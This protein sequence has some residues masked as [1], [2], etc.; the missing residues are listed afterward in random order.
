MPMVGKTVT[1]SL[2]IQVCE[3]SHAC[4]RFYV[5]PSIWMMTFTPHMFIVKGFK[6]LP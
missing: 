2:A 5:Y 1:V 4:P 3:I 6:K